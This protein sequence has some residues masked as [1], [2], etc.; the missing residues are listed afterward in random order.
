M[1][2]HY[3][4]GKNCPV[5]K[6]RERLLAEA[7]QLCELYEEALKHVESV[8]SGEPAEMILRNDINGSRH[9]MRRDPN[10]GNLL[11]T[12]QFRNGSHTISLAFD[13]HSPHVVEGLASIPLAISK[14]LIVEAD[15]LVEATKLGVDPKDHDEMDKL[16]S[17][18]AAKLGGREANA[19]DNLEALLA[20]L[21][22]KP[23]VK[24]VVGDNLHDAVEQALKMAAGSDTID[25][26]DTKH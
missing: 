3:V 19:D 20:K 12:I 15:A 10:F 21:S 22:G 5:N 26:N 7:P 9:G 16:Y 25:N 4:H 6:L 23:N 11:A 17:K 2:K 14:T 18:A 8:E 24:V 1:E 13:P